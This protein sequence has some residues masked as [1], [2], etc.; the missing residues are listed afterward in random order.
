MRETRDDSHAERLNSLTNKLLDVNESADVCIKEL[1]V[2]EQQRK[3]FKID[4]FPLP[5]FDGNIRKYP[6]FKRDFT[7][8]VRPQI[9]PKQGPFVLRQCLSEQ[10]QSNI[11]S[12]DDDLDAMFKMM[13]LK[14]G[15]SGKLVEAIVS[16]I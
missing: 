6:L 12:Y 13:D 2:I 3:A 16:E 14:Y 10:I 7:E 11:G 5:K 8:F 9:S 15:D 1:N 4:K